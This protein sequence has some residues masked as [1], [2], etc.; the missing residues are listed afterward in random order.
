LENARAEYASAVELDPGFSIAK[1]KLNLISIKRLSMSTIEKLASYEERLASTE[2]TLL[3]AGAKI[4][5]ILGV[6]NQE[7][8]SRGPITGFGTIRVSGAL[9]VDK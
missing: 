4:G 8:T 9:P 6:D 2:P 3:G 1:R 5:L 7:V